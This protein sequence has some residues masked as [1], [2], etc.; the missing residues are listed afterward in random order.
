IESA[1]SSFKPL[2][3]EKE[4]HLSLRPPVPPLAILCDRARIELALCNLLDNAVKFVSVGGQ[5]E[6]GAE[7]AGQAIRLWVRDNGP[8]I[9]PDDRPHIFERFYRG[10]Y[11]RTDGSGL[12]LTIVQSIVQAHGG[13][14]LAESEPG[15]GSLFAIEL[16]SPPQ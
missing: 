11:V 16:P 7:Q 9:D 15:H 8:G 10:L 1:A 4:I 13:R 3:Q 6:I 5:V 14:V 12:G 2:V